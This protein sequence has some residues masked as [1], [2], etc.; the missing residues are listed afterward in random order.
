MNKGKLRELLKEVSHL[1]D[2]NCHNEARLKLAVSF[3]LFDVARILMALDTI[4]KIEQ[5][6]PRGLILYREHVT[7]RILKHVGEK[8]GPATKEK[9]LKALIIKKD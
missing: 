4:H 3:N 1:I 6:L 5:D 8:H 2:M 9:L 7:G